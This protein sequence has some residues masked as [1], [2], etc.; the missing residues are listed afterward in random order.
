[1]GYCDWGQSD[2]TLYQRLNGNETFGPIK[3]IVLVAV[4]ALIEFQLRPIAM[5]KSKDYNILPS[6]R[7]KNHK[8]WFGG[9][10]A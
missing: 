6:F 3:N 7:Q 8:I 10:P 9:E 1:L 5:A 2:K 4:F